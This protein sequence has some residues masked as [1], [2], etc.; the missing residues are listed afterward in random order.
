MKR[1]KEL[2]KREKG[3]GRK[4]QGI[5]RLENRQ[6]DLKKQINKLKIIKTDKS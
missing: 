1:K 2:K 3:K 4:Q 6:H 5:G